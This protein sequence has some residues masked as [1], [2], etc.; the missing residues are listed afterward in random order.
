MGLS[1]S[2]SNYS[3]EQSYMQ[4]KDQCLCCSLGI[5]DYIISSGNCIMVFK[6]NGKNSTKWIYFEGDTSDI[7]DYNCNLN[8]IDTIKLKKVGHIFDNFYEMIAY[9]KTY[10][11][12]NDFVKQIIDYQH[13]VINVNYMDQIV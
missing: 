8:I 13:K 4:K 5:F 7:I 6:D 2:T 1:L 9:I 11:A 10:C 3:L 12:E